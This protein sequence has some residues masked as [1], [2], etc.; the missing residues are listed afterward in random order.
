MTLFDYGVF[1]IIAISIGLGWWRGFVYELLSIAGWLLAYFVARLFSTELSE[2]VPDVVATGAAKTMVA[3]GVLFIGTLMLSALA[4]WFVSKV[5]KFIG[6]GW[7]NSLLGVG[8]GLVRGI[9]V[10][11]ILVLLG[12]LT[13]VPKMP[14]WHEAWSSERWQAAALM[15]KDFLPDTLAKRVSY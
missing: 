15:A 14:F 6:L 2:L 8:F 10:V 13:Q 5:V 1:L 7:I 12:G 4:S 3:Y 11:L 9:L